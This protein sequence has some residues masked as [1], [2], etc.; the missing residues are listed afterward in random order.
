MYRFF[1]MFSES[2]RV[3]D[4]NSGTEEEPYILR[5]TL[6]SVFKDQKIEGRSQTQTYN[7]DNRIREDLFANSSVN[8]LLHAPCKRYGGKNKGRTKSNPKPGAPV[9][10]IYIPSCLYL[11]SPFNDFSVCSEKT[12]PSVF[13]IICPF[14]SVRYTFIPAAFSLSKAPCRGRL[15]L[16]PALTVITAA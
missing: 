16:L 8:Q 1:R 14:R 4:I 13:N 2:E 3:I 10:L 11:G 9:P 15:Y 5:G 12:F 7:K 6:H